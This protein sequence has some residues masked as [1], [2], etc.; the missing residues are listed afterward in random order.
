[1]WP[2]DADNNDEV[3]W[4]SKVYYWIPIV[5]TNPPGC[6]LVYR[7]R[8]KKNVEWEWDEYCSE[9]DID[10]ELCQSLVL[11]PAL[12]ENDW[13]IFIKIAVEI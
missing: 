5:H 12:F 4:M 1:M 7:M 9:D 10:N 11:T 3:E 2:Y 6:Q 13:D 8:E